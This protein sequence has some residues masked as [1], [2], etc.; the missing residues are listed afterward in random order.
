MKLTHFIQTEMEQLLGSWEEAA[1]K[2]EPKLKGKGRCTLKDQAREVLERVTQDLDTF[3]LKDEPERNPLGNGKSPALGFD[4][5]HGARRFQQSFFILQ[6]IRELRARVTRA[7]GCEQ[8][9]L[10]EKDIDE[11]VRFNEAIDG[12]IGHLVPSFSPHRGQDTR[13]IETMLKANIDPAALFDTNGKHLFIETGIADLVNAPQRDVIGETPLELFLDL[14]TELLDAIT[15]TVATGETQH[16]EF[17]H[18]VPFNFNCQFVPVFNDRNEVEAV[19]KTSRKITER[20]QTEF[21]VWRNANF[22]SLTGLPNRRLF[23]DRLKQT[24]LE[25]Q[26]ESS[27]FA[28]LVIDFDRFNQTKNQLGQETGD[29]LLEQVAERI[30]AKVRAMDTLAR[31]E[32]EEFTLILTKTDSGGAKKAAKRLLT[33]L[34]QAFEVDSQRVHLSASMGLTLFPDDGK[35]NDQMMHNAHRAKDTAKAHGGHQVRFYEPWMS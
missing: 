21:Q 6:M 19:V 11:L 20:K 30:S 1:P 14:A 13:L 29:R 17:H 10:T 32:G 12:L 23:L 31:L 18:G 34:E 22:D 33:S 8:R 16:R 15:T 4:S 9:G 26:R 5:G 25:A 35:N 7:W 24:F 2:A 28:L 27:S 3:P